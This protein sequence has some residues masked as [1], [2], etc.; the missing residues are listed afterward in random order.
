ME[1]N[2]NNMSDMEIIQDL[3]SS[4]S[5]VL[6]TDSCVTKDEKFIRA[7]LDRLKN[8]DM[9]LY[10]Q[11]AYTINSTIIKRITNSAD[12]TIDYLS[13]TK[14]IVFPVDALP[15]TIKNYVLEVAENLQVSV[16]MV[17]VTAL[18]M[19]S[20]SLQGRFNVNI[21][22]G[23]NEPLNLFCAIIASPSERKS[24]VVNLLRKPIIEYEKEE[25]ERLKPQIIKS[26]LTKEALDAKKAKLIKKDT[27]NLDEISNELLNFK[28]IKPVKIFV[29][30]ITSEKLSS[31][32]AENNN[33]MS[34]ISCEGGIFETM[35]GKYNQNNI[36]IDVFLKGYS[37]DTL[38]VDRVSRES[39][40]I[41][42]PRLGM[43]LAIQPSILE[44]I[45]RNQQFS[46]RGLLARFL[47][48]FP[49]SLVGTRKFKTKE[50][51]NI[52]QEQYEKIVKRGL[53]MEIGK[54][55][56]IYFNDEA[57]EILENFYNEI[58]SKSAT[59]YESIADWCGKLLGNTSRIAGILALINNIETNTIN[60]KDVENAI[61]IA[62]YFLQNTINIFQL[63]SFSRKIKD[64]NYILDF[65]IEKRI[66]LFKI[67]E[68]I[69]GRRSFRSNE[70]ANKGLEELMRRNYIF[71]DDE[72][73]T[74]FVNPDIYKDSHVV[75]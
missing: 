55:K 28:E 42:N 11:T 18:E 46:G 6:L 47:Y 52:L 9:D 54:E 16:D 64:A 41:E 65:I 62:R 12:T 2:L 57:K 71:Y 68:L 19:I 66:Y 17:A 4:D 1:E 34:I 50:V 37:G 75:T 40:I 15:E 10:R 5:Q 8:I 45:I 53:R 59:E 38:K 3:A 72:T 21:K 13:R 56:T 67:R 44:E 14:D 33:I 74:Y 49:T 70:D 58:E 29:D 73:K 20:T 63:S 32:L 39:E 48:C 23:W 7:L 43:L 30:D 36:N 22:S 51:S 60:S 26:R 61:L 35:A 25:N 31:L 69:R 27:I 24:P